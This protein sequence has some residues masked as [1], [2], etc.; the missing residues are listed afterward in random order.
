MKLAAL[1]LYL[2]LSVVYSLLSIGDTW[3]IEVTHNE[4]PSIFHVTFNIHI[5]LEGK[6]LIPFFQIEKLKHKDHI[7]CLRLHSK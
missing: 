6:F 3:T 5:H 4:W 1:L 7:I 2:T